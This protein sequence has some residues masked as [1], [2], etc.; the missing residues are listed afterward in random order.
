MLSAYTAS[1]VGI[2]MLLY[3]WT[4]DANPQSYNKETTEK[5]LTDHVV[6]L[7][8]ILYPQMLLLCMLQ[9]ER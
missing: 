7:I 5:S 8:K 9:R 6:M 4:N 1:S 3:W 2:H